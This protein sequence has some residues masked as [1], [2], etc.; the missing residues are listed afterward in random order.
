MKLLEKRKK[1]TRCED[2]GNNIVDNN[3]IIYKAELEK[4]IF[5]INEYFTALA[6]TNECIVDEKNGEIKYI[7]ILR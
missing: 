4:D 5:Y 6:I 1:N 2:N 7:Y 3:Q